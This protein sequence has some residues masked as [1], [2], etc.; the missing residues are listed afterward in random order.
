M[1]KHRILFKVFILAYFCSI[2]FLSQSSLNACYHDTTI[3]NQHGLQYHTIGKGFKKKIENLDR[4]R[5][6]G[7]INLLSQVYEKFIKTFAEQT[8]Y[9]PEG[10]SPSSESKII[11]PA[12]ILFVIKSIIFMTNQIPIFVEIIEPIEK[13]LSPRA[14][15][16][17]KEALTEHLSHCYE[18]EKSHKEFEDF[19]NEL[20]KIVKWRLLEFYSKID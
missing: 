19:L 12:N 13:Q 2:L 4:M 10:R 16:A 5:R 18:V 14:I 11:S 8:L 17:Y 3:Q 15:S 7:K 9:G 6:V 1:K 20:H